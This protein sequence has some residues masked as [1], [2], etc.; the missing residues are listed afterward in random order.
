MILVY[1][2]ILTTV[3][4]NKYKL[5]AALLASSKCR[6]RAKGQLIRER[7]L[8]NPIMTL[9]PWCRAPVSLKTNWPGPHKCRLP[10][11][12]TT[13][14]AL[15]TTLR[16]YPWITPVRSRSVSGWAKCLTCLKIFN[17]R[18]CL[19]VTKHLCK[20][21]CVCFERKSTENKKRQTSDKEEETL[22][23]V[24]SWRSSW[25]KTKTDRMLQGGE[26]ETRM[27]NSRVWLTETQALSLSLKD[28]KDL[29]SPIL[30]KTLV[31]LWLRSGTRSTTE[32]GG[33]TQSKL[34][35]AGD[36]AFLMSELGKGQ[37]LWTCSRSKRMSSSS[38]L[39]ML[40]AVKIDNS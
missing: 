29:R 12:L 27:A 33:D 23:R 2:L 7:L 34:G 28:N 32:V 15:S 24:L 18:W 10:P 16:D 38:Q 13:M 31:E 4:Y 36:L 21:F 8:W 25:L 39:P 11:T 30:S 3:L 9:S 6:S 35:E 1:Y 37:C 40:F 19:K 5:P 22:R 20:R 17:N 14:I 26:S